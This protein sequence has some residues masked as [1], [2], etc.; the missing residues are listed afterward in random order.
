MKEWQNN[1]VNDKVYIAYFRTATKGIEN[2]D[3]STIRK[4][5]KLINLKKTCHYKFDGLVSMCHNSIYI[6]SY[7]F[8]DF[9]ET[10]GC[11]K[12]GIIDLI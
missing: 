2:K 8:S 12:G 9:S 4:Q 3:L 1:L 7:L 5:I 10:Y 11:P 6:Y